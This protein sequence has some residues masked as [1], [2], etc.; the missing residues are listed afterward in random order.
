MTQKSKLLTKKGAAS[1][2]IVVFSILLFTI[3]AL[4]FMRIVLRGNQTATEN[5][6]SQS[7]YDS[8][9]AGVE[10]AKRALV[11]Y[12]RQCASC[13]ETG[14]CDE[15]CTT[16]KTSFSGQDCDV[17]KNVLSGTS[18]I[19][20]EILQ[21]GSYDGLR[22][23]YTCV[24]V[25]YDTPDYIGEFKSVEDNYLISLRSPAGSVNVN[26]LRINWFSQEDLTQDRTVD[27][28]SVTSIGGLPASDQ[29]PSTRPPILVAQLFKISDLTNYDID[30][31]VHPKQPASWNLTLFPTSDSVEIADFRKDSRRG[32][33]AADNAPVSDAPVVGVRCQNLDSV[34]YACSALIDLPEPIT[35]SNDNY[36]LR[37]S[38][39]YFSKANFQVEMLNTASGDPILFSGVQP[40][41]DSNGRADDFFRRVEARVDSSLLGNFPLPVGGVEVAK[42][43]F[44]KDLYIADIMSRSNCQ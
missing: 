40:A 17:V 35:A 24:K 16:L 38:K 41:I 33:R 42:G 20:E 36:F 5:D 14:V 27:L 23:A 29:W 3:L 22:Q 32:Y 26:K 9:V 25:A 6:L 30:S 43:D 10:D 2:F 18:G 13:I 31:S 44:C 34:K 4:S 28:P 15:T 21:T 39:R 11:A 1:L 8:A 19:D 7:A 37:L 12:T